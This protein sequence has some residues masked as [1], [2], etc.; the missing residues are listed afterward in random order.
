[1]FYAP[2]PAPHDTVVVNIL[3]VT[4]KTKPLLLVFVYKGDP[5]FTLRRLLDF[6][7]FLSWGFDKVFSRELEP[8]KVLSH[9]FINGS[10]F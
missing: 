5:S 3:R 6:P 9:L 4:L 2:T 7:T 8:E 1:M 10:A